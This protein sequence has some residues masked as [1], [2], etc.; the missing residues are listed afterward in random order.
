[1]ADV[2]DAIGRLERAINTRNGEDPLSISVV[3]NATSSL[4]IPCPKEITNGAPGWIIDLS[5]CERCPFHKYS[6]SSGNFEKITR[7]NPETKERQHTIILIDQDRDPVLGLMGGEGY[8][9]PQ[10]GVMCAY[11]DVE[12]MR[13]TPQYQKLFEKFREEDPRMFEATRRQEMNPDS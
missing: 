11:P 6:W 10:R 5:A 13:E 9:A 8:V 3:D 1:M 7:F 4:G 2:V 12:R